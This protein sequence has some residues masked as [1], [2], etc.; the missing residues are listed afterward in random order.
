M[1]LRPH[2]LIPAAG[3]INPRHDDEVAEA[4]LDRLERFALV[5]VIENPRLTDNL[6]VWLDRS[7]SIGVVNRTEII[8]ARHRRPLDQE[9]TPEVWELIHHRSRLDG[10]LWR[11][12]TAARLTKDERSDLTAREIERAVGR[13]RALMAA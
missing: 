12:V 11:A 7:V 2:P 10:R 3:E 5:D 9:L 1:L 13:Y 4:A 6:S 8:A